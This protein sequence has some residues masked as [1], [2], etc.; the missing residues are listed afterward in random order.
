MTAPG[1]SSS[2]K[3]LGP[4]RR[5][6]RCTFCAHL[7]GA[8]SAGAPAYCPSPSGGVSPQGQEP[9]ASRSGSVEDAGGQAD[10][11][12][13][14][15]CVRVGVRD[16]WCHRGTLGVSLGL[17]VVTG[18]LYIAPAGGVAERSKAAAFQAVGTL[19]GARGSESHLLREEAR[20]QEGPP[21]G[22]SCRLR[23]YG[24]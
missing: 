3:L 16:V 17:T 18:G 9:L 11:D 13:D 23:V 24:P 4:S 19:S 21:N 2:P 7:P 15:P 10:G 8:L 14:Q 5:T 20:A 1:D 12:R 22:P 6:C